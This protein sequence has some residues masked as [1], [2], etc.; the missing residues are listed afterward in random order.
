MSATMM[1]SNSNPNPYDDRDIYNT[2]DALEMNCHNICSENELVTDAKIYAEG[3]NIIIE[4]AV[5]QS[6]VICDVAGHARTVNLMA[7]L[8]EIPVNSSGLYI[9][10]LREKSAKLLI[11]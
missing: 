3:Q 6:A 2:D 8:N 11:K 4:S 7:G 10:R 5:E 1:Y 9:V